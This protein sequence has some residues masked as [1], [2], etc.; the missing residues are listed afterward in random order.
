[1]KEQN[2]TTGKEL[3]K[4]ET[5]NLLAA[6]FKTLVIRLLKEL[7]EDLN[8]IK[9]IQS[10][11]KVALIKI[12]NNLQG[13]NSRVD[14]AENQISDL[15]YKEKTNN[16]SEQQEEQRIPPN[17]DS[18]RSLW[19][20]FKQTNISIMGVLEGGEREQEIGNLVE[21]IMTENFPNLVNWLYVQAQE[22]QRVPNKM[23]PKRPTP[24]HIIIQIPKVKDKES[25]KSIKRKTDSYLQGSPHETVSWFLKRNFA[26]YIQ[27]DEKQGSTIKIT[28]PSKVII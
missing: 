18:I 5:S 23:N 19:D 15:E 25:L 26:G 1:M 4:R 12:K 28:L 9:K 22:A 14:E 7:S 21:K 13:I 6:Q 2:K 8:S 20:N 11:M 10:K 27:S 16:Q 3:N 24:R 17:E